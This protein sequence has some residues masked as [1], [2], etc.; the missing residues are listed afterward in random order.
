MIVLIF[1]FVVVSMFVSLAELTFH[2]NYRALWFPRWVST[3]AASALVAGSPKENAVNIIITVF[4][5][6]FWSFDQNV[7]FCSAIQTLKE[8]RFKAG[9]ELLVALHVTSDTDTHRSQGQGQDLP[10]QKLHRS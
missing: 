9:L 10:S 1:T 4:C 8:P 6:R 3:C 7:T 5:T 2:N